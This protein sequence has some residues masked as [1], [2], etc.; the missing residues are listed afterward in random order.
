[1][2]CLT[3]VQSFAV[4]ESVW[5]NLNNTEAQTSVKYYHTWWINVICKKKKLTKTCRFIEAKSTSFQV[6]P[7]PA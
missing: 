7:E 1:M 6:Q 3:Q 5:W 2:R 4:F